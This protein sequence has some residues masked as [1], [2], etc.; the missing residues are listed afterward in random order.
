MQLLEEHHSE[1]NNID[2]TIVCEDPVITRHVSRM[3]SATAGALNIPEG[4]LNIKGKTTEGMGFTG[5]REG[6]A[7]F[8]IVT[9]KTVK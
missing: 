2:V 7:A 6:I 4:S 1:I 8:A 3:K 9:I 5:S